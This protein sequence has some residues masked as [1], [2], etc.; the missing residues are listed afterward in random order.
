ME[1]E[2]EQIVESFL[3]DFDA[4]R[5]EAYAR[6]FVEGPRLVLIIPRV[7]VLRGLGAY[8]EYESKS[9]K[10]QGRATS[11]EDRTIEVF[12][13][14]A[15]VMGRMTMAFSAGQERREIREH[16]AFMLERDDQNGWK[17]FHLQATLAD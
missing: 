7:G 2:I 11:W 8:L 3:A 15:R 4:A 13:D 5:L 14:F 16:I 17:C 6:F 1:K 12:G 10:L 9:A